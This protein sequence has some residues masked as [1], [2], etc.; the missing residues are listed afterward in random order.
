MNLLQS[1]KK[2]HTLVILQC[3]KDEYYAMGSETITGMGLLSFHQALQEACEEEKLESTTV[4]CIEACSY[5][6]RLLP[7]ADGTLP[8]VNGKI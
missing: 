6:P 1:G 8:K 3:A 2:A 5:C 7:K 4:F